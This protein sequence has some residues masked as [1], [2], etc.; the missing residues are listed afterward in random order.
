MSTSQYVVLNKYI[1]DV[2][3]VGIQT[4]STGKFR[5]A[6]HVKMQNCGYFK[7][8]RISMY[9]FSKMWEFKYVGTKN[10]ITRKFMGN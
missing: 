7:C 6:K 5:Y 10:M 3:C 8:V 9:A 4:L 2:R 1:F